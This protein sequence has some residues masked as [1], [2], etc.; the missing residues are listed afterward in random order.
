[1]V[2]IT[3]LIG[4]SPAGAKLSILSYNATSF[5]GNFIIITTGSGDIVKNF[6]DTPSS[7]WGATV[8]YSN[9]IIFT[10]DLTTAI[11]IVFFLVPIA[12]S[13]PTT[14]TLAPPTTPPYNGPYTFDP[15][16]TLIDLTVAIDASSLNKGFNDCKNTLQKIA[17]LYSYDSGNARLSFFGFSP[18]ANI[19][20]GLNEP[21]SLDNVTLQNVWTTLK[22]ITGGNGY[23]NVFAPF[24]NYF[25]QVQDGPY[26]FRDNVQRVFLYCTSIDAGKP[27]STDV[28]LIQGLIDDNDL[29]V[30][31][32]NLN[33]TSSFDTAFFQNLIQ[34][35]GTGSSKA[36]A[37]SVTES[38]PLDV[39]KIVNEYIQN[40]NQ[41]CSLPSSSDAI[42]LDLWRDN[43][44]NVPIPDAHV[45]CNYMNSVQIYHA[46][47]SQVVRFKFDDFNLN[48]NKDFV[49]VSTD[50][51]EVGRITGY[52]GYTYFCV[53][54]NDTVT[55]TFTSTGDKV[56]SG[57]TGAVT[58]FP[59]IDTC[60]TPPSKLT[61]PSSSSSPSG[62]YKVGQYHEYKYIHL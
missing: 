30:I 28:Q 58:A 23:S 50:N 8:D 48:Y 47:P 4:G 44:F 19:G 43:S 25:E 26:K 10:F 16:L 5:A 34:L 20:F 12:Q 51:V 18:T 32:I 36:Y 33:S 3:G 14:T 1:V 57:F 53:Q 7:S 49:I 60:K 46:K 52:T 54:A 55:L 29:K 27:G 2:N 31:I 59:D 38:S 37:Y 24:K 15:S 22:P 45:Y 56:Y 42:L 61:T 40:G 41:L 39:K 62:N 35:T 17:S 13:L 11:D 9:V 6:T 21:W